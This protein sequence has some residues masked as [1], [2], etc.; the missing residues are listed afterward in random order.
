MNEFGRVDAL[1]NGA[2]G[3]MPGATIGPDK[4]IFDLD[5]D[6]YS[7]VM[8]LN[9]KGTVLPTLDFAKAFKAQGHGSVINF[10][11]MSSG[12]ALDPGFGIFQCKGG[13]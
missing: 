9:L 8:D 2:G 4:E 11:S 3:N 7:Q 6:D 10:S 13:H 12:Q 1:I 5:I